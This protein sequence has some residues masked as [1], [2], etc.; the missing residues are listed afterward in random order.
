MRFD[1]EAECYG[2]FLDLNFIARELQRLQADNAA[3]RTQFSEK[4]TIT[5]ANSP[6]TSMTTIAV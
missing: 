3:L 2:C 1:D 5:F 4:L 6:A